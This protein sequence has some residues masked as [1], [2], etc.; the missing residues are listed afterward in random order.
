MK[1][2]QREVFCSWAPISLSLGKTVFRRC[3]RY[4]KGAI[5]QLTKSTA[6]DYAAF[7]IRGAFHPGTIQTPLL[8]NAVKQ[9]VAKSGAKQLLYSLTVR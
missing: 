6:I 8:D 7:N 4:D 5:A 1:Q 3:I 2:Q 9:F